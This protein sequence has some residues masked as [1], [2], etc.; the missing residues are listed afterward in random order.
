[1]PG[2]EKAPAGNTLTV[3][4][5]L[6]DKDPDL[7]DALHN[8]NMR[9]PRGEGSFTLFSA[10]GWANGL[11]L[12]LLIVGL[13]TLFI[14]YPVIYHFTHPSPPITGF[15]LGGIN[16]SGQIPVLPGLS[17]LIDPDT[18]S[19]ALTR[20]GSDGKKYNLVFSDEF[21]T[22][23]RSFFPGDDAFWEAVDFHYW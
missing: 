10:R 12:L 3:P 6:W 18:P 22:D 14:G 19:S 23:G 7:D 4:Q 9:D 16:G 1:M 8:P 21:N 13:I 20:T 5:Y 15:N 11:A 2:P 17:S